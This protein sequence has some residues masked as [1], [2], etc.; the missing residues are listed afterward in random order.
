M[1]EDTICAISTPLGE[2]GIGVIRL[3]GEKAIEIAD[4][5]IRL[6]GKTPLMQH[7]SHTL[8]YGHV[9]DPVSQEI[10]DEVMVAVLRAPK[11]YTREDMVEISGHGGPVPLACTLRILL[12]Q[13]ARLAEPGEFTKR[14]FLNGRIDLSQ[15][16]A[17]L[18]VIRA[19]TEGSLKAALRQ[20]SGALSSRLREIREDLLDLLAL[21][22]AGIDF[23]EEEIDHASPQM[24]CEKARAAA[25]RVK[26]LLSTAEEG[27]I[28]REGVSAVIV[29]RPNVGKSSLLNALLMEDRAIVAPAPGTTRDVL[30]E[31]LNVKGVPVRLLDTAG[32]R[33]TTEEVEKEGVRRTRAAMENADILLCVFDGS[34]RLREEDRL[35]MQ[36]LDGK[37]KIVLLNKADIGQQIEEAEIRET[38]PADPVLSVSTVTHAGLDALRDTL[39]GAILRG[40]ETGHAHEGALVATMRQRVALSKA[41]ESLDKL[42]DSAEARM[43]HEFLAVDLRTALDSIGSVIGAVTTEDVLDR[44]FSSFCIGK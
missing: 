11:T 8:H 4:R 40:M 14:A 17:V 2:G 38:L 15:A 6:K 31:H 7:P 26:K 37:R 19:K 1:Q 44:I 29:G 9:V 5:A 41:V 25:A 16:E 13:G 23:S 42:H 32:M 43:P 20:L 18:D 39:A 36:V 27:R 21:I 35:L 24:I 10:A 33:E 28:Y 30:E 3:S 22:E 12:T 34:E